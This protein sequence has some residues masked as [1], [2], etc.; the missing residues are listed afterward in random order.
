MW[1]VRKKIC[2][3]G[4]K[5]LCYFL[6]KDK[7]LPATLQQRRAEKL[8]PQFDHYVPFENAQKFNKYAKNIQKMFQKAEKNMR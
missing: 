2:I 4:A 1:G 8:F 7:H 6:N 5:F 3:L